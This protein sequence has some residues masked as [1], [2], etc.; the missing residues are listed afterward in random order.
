MLKHPR[1]G[2]TPWSYKVTILLSLAGVTF[3]TDDT[4][5]Y[6]VNLT[7]AAVP[8]DSIFTD[9]L[10][11]HKDQPGPFTEF[12]PTISHLAKLSS[13]YLCT[14]LYKIVQYT[15]THSTP[16]H[17]VYSLITIP[18]LIVMLTHLSVDLTLTSPCKAT[19]LLPRAVPLSTARAPIH[20][21][22]SSPCTRFIL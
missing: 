11:I 14:I 3:F 5:I 22:H 8:I 17:K 4:L 2:F 20:S 13:D 1:V 18:S 19:R 15:R 12:P 10:L 6:V 21:I 9:C 16:L 7:N